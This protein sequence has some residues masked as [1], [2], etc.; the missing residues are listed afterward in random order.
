MS[1][2]EKARERAIAIVET[3]TTGVG[4]RAAGQ[5]YPQVW[6]RDAVIAGLG[7][8]VNGA[9]GGCPA[10]AGSLASL[11][12]AQSDLGRIP[13]NIMTVGDP[14]TGTSIEADTMFA[15]AIDAA[16]WFII[17][18]YVLAV[19]END[20]PALSKAWPALERAHLWLRY[21]DSNECGLLEVHE[22]MDWADLF[23]NHYNSLLPNVL[24]YGAN[25]AMAHLATRLGREA[26][27][28]A[29]RATDI[30]HKLNQLLWVGPEYEPDLNWIRRHRAEWQYPVELAR[31]TLVQRPYYLPYVA[32]RDF[33]D[34]LDT[35][36]NLLAILFGVAEP[37]QADRILDYIVAA[38][39]DQPWPIKAC[40]PPVMPGEKDWREYYRMYNLNLPHQYHNGGA[41]PFI[42]G[43]YVAAL[44][45]AGRQAQA[46][47]VLERLASM[48]RHG[49]RGATW[50]FNEW[51]HGLSG[52][53]MGH[54]E[55]TWSAG[56]FLYAHEAVLTGACPFFD[57]ATGW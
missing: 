18:H 37:A 25:R 57:P 22:S 42:G 9:A 35:L 53:P 32:F 3:N 17:G 34:R 20:D 5:A 39:V 29:D 43:F 1:T 47:D 2:V 36:G 11:G 31:T 30:R 45:Q 38:G 24:W 56:M 49:Q 55:Q 23:A 48:N 19:Q 27:P 8:A 10:L 46:H 26:G 7:M 14:N 28:F 4:L 33:G 16:A 13:N 6:A 41:W 51:F 54:G 44:V 40:W 21:Q 15:G 12:A 50:Q 52:Q